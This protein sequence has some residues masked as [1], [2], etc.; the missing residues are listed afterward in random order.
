VAVPRA[1]DEGVNERKA[2]QDKRDELRV[3]MEGLPVRGR[4]VAW[5]KQ[6]RVSRKKVEE[7][8]E[9]QGRGQLIA[10]AELVEIK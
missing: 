2:Q 9:R 6:A 7:G 5:A 3:T 1:W 10:D 8:R 4:R